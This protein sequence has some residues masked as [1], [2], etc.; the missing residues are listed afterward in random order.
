M[1]CTIYINETGKKS[2]EEE[3]AMFEYEDGW[4]R[5][6]KLEIMIK[7]I[8]DETVDWKEIHISIKEE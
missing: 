1:E 5:R 2:D 3:Y 8:L 4:D 7:D 6:D